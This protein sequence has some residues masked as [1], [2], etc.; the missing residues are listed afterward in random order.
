M[1]TTKT[2]AARLADLEDAVREAEQR[3]AEVERGR[4][5]ASRALSQAEGARLA[6][7]E[8]RAAGESVSDEEIETAVKAISEARE[9][10]DAA[11][12]NARFEGAARAVAEA[13]MARDEFGRRA[14]AEIAAEEVPLDDPAREALQAA[15][16]A[17][18][19]AAGVYSV[20]TRRWHHLARYGGIA[21]ESIPNGTPLRGDFAEVVARFEGGLPVPTPPTLR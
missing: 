13:E 2:A 5:R 14:F 10:A 16:A 12:W 4:N 9:A 1:A 21:A 11:V 20:R 3:R 6:L 18:V 7:E 17:L 8:S 19:D 15:W